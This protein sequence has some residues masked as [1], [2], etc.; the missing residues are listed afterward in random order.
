MPI[1]NA[2]SSGRCPST[3][4]GRCAIIERKGGPQP[5]SQISRRQRL[6]FIGRKMRRLEIALA[7]CLL[8]T[9]VLT[10]AYWVDVF[11]GGHV[12]VSTEE[13]YVRF[14]RAFPAADCWM[15]CCCVIGGL[16]LL[17]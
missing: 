5:N 9:A 8:L 11:S 17:R 13:W 3:L 7:V 15:S 10:T 2:S 16:G 1:R 6:R 12:Q 14:E 4:T